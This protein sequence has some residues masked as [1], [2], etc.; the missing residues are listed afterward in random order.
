MSRGAC[1]CRT[2]PAENTEVGTDIRNQ[3]I[4]QQPH[5]IL[6]GLVR[7]GCVH[8]P[9]SIPG[10]RAVERGFGV[11]RGLSSPQQQPSY[12]PFSP[13][14]TPPSR[15][16][17]LRTGKSALQRGRGGKHPAL[18]LLTPHRGAHLAGPS[19]SKA[20]LQAAALQT[21]ARPA[22]RLGQRGAFGVRW[23]QHRFSRRAF[24]ISFA[25]F[26]PS[27][28]APFPAGGRFRC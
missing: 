15:A 4:S 6:F 1:R 10:A 12:P 25:P 20:A 16:T 26:A 17:L 14:P 21:L 3:S 11:E 23:L 28:A 27:R 5:C 2:P 7:E 9:K 19:V 13:V 18:M 22:T 8:A 24:S